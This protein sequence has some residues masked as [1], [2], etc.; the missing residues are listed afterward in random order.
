MYKITAHRIYDMH[1]KR[2]NRI[3]ATCG[4][5]PKYRNKSKSIKIKRVCRAAVSDGD[6][7]G[8]I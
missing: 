1:D 6:S 7:K 8:V 3:R 2:E 4:L 5:R